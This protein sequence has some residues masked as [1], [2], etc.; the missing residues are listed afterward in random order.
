[1]TCPIPREGEGS[2]CSDFCDGPANCTCFEGVFGEDG[3]EADGGSL[4]ASTDVRNMPPL[5][6]WREIGEAGAERRPTL[7]VPDRGRSDPASAPAPSS[8]QRGLCLGCSRKSA[9]FGVGWTRLSCTLY[10]PGSGRCS[11]QRLSAPGLME[12]VNLEVQGP[13]SFP[14][15]ANEACSVGLVGLS[16]ERLRS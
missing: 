8:S 2:C 1:M 4:S 14:V 15:L 13:S 10:H 7:P 6:R 11:V 9:L 12:A 5:L 3:A 16:G